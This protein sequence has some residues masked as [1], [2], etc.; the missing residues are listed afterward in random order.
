MVQNENFLSDDDY[1][2]DDN[3]DDNNNKDDHHTDYH[4]RGSQQRQPQKD[5]NNK[6][7]K[8]N[9]GNSFSSSTLK[10][11]EWPPNCRILFFNTKIDKFFAV[12]RTS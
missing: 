2:D 5:N 3:G 7:N 9:E 12:C 6:D 1:D 8:I 10:Y 4:Q 11:V